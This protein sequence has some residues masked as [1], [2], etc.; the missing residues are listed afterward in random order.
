VPADKTVL[1]VSKGDDELLRFERQRGWHFPQNAEGVY[2]GYY[3]VDSSEA[4][5]QL[6]QLRAKGA[7][8][9]LF[10]ASAS[11]W[12]QHYTAFKTHLERRYRAL[13]IRSG[14][15]RIFALNDVNGGNGEIHGS[16]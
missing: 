2:A 14:A 12:L 3:P 16:N 1:V 5:A 15:C 9:L 4:I 13:E 11:W 6:E 8:Y 7:E 10:P